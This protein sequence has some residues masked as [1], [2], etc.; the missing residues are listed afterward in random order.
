MAC[1]TALGCNNDD[2]IHA[3]INEGLYPVITNPKNETEQFI[4]NFYSKYNC[5]IIPQPEPKH[6]KYN[7]TSINNKYVVKPEYSHE[8]M[9][10]A[11]EYIEYIFKDYDDAF[12][13]KYLPLTIQLADSICPYD[14]Y[15]KPIVSELN[16]CFASSNLLMIGN[17]NQVYFN[18]MTDET[19]RNTA[20]EILAHYWYRY[21]LAYRNCIPI[22]KEF[23]TAIGKPNLYRIGLVSALKESVVL[24]LLA[25]WGFAGYSPS[26]YKRNQYCTP[27][28]T[29]DYE[30]FFRLMLTNTEAQ[31]REKY[32][33]YPIFLKRYEMIQSAVKKG[34][35]YEFTTFK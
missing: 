35:N 6:Y 1:L 10:K 34:M 23:G 9:G 13:K 7:F 25:Q 4:Y 3:D 5:L 12:K 14:T 29:E 20:I 2:R 18:S 19:K 24:D 26:N 22:N 30:L 27:S 28:E 32:S 21:L 31:I 17:I 8:L 11:F 16:L 33:K 15:Q